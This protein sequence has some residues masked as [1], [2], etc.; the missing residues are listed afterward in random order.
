MRGFTFVT[1]SAAKVAEARRILGHEIEHRPMALPEIQAVDLDPV[2][3]AKARYAFEALGERPV[4]VEDTG[5]FIEAWNG[6]PG[7][8]AKWFV[9]RVGPA[10]LC[11]MLAAFPH[12]AASAETLVAT[13]DGQLQTF[14]GRMR[15]RIAAA[16]AG[17]DGFGWDAVFIPEGSD[18]TYAE[19][20]GADKDAFSMRR[21]ALEAL[22]RHYAAR[23]GTGG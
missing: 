8:L 15:G 7:A 1:E 3:E 13:Y 9:E 10:G 21:L 22:Q 2:V 19:L 5:L 18:R 12:R 17:N 14:R 16:P 23:A 11:A 6:L 4:L 20:S